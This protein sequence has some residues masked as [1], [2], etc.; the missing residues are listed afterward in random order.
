MC[1]HPFFVVLCCA[2]LQIIRILEKLSPK[3][4]YLFHSVS[5]IISNRC[6]SEQID[7]V[8]TA[9]STDSNNKETVTTAFPFLLTSKITADS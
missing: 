8:Q 3:Q 4:A 7:S 9:E 5:S 1:W 2:L 6:T